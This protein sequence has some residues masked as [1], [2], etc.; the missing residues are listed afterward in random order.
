MHGDIVCYGVISS[1]NQLS[2]LRLHSAN[3]VLR[4]THTKQPALQQVCGVYIYLSSPMM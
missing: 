3:M 4:M 2:L 1:A